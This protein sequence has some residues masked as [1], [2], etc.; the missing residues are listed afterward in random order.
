MVTKKLLDPISNKSIVEKVIDRITD[1]IISGELKR[2]SK[3][4]TE[5][6]LSEHLNVGRNSVREAIKVLVYMG[7][8][9]IRRAEGTFVKE[10]FSDKMLNPIL[11]SL[12]LEDGDSSSL[13]EFR[14]VFD[15]GTLRLAIQNATDEDIENIKSKCESLIYQIK[16]NSMD[17][18]KVLN[19]DIDF[20]NA[21]EQ[22]AHNT[23]ILKISSIVTK[24]TIPSRLKATKSIINSDNISFLIDSH[25]NILNIVISKD[26]S[27]VIDVVDNSYLYWQNTLSN[28][29]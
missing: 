5:V 10:G 1:A 19:A 22:A 16:N 12:I 25:L 28:E 8:L 21:I 26:I 3:I 4:P 11:Y 27:R 7:V 24:L 9:E 14:K 23:L 18:E 13:I 6:E 2:G 20:H 17:S 15:V 29:Q